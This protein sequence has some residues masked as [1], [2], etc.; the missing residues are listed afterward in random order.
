MSEPGKSGPGAANRGNIDPQER[1]Q[2]EA[3]NTEEPEQGAIRG[4]DRSRGQ[5]NSCEAAKIDLATEHGVRQ[6][7]AA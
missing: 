7:L 5:P 4:D 3:R 2:L 6:E 1:E